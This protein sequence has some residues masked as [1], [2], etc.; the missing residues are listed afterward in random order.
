V[1]KS[2]G[3]LEGDIQRVERQIG[4]QHRVA[5]LGIKV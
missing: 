2:V 4:Q 3:E 5:T 1:K